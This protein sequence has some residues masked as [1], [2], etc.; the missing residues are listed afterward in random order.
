M[1]TY[2]IGVATLLVQAQAFGQLAVLVEVHFEWVEP[3]EDV[4]V[5]HVKG[6]TSRQFEHVV[7]SLYHDGTVTRAPALGA[8]LS[9]NCMDLKQQCRGDVNISH[10][11]MTKTCLE[12]LVTCV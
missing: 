11:R 5:T 1:Y 2:V 7:T 3:T 9:L 12:T 8:T 6:G 10:S 4:G